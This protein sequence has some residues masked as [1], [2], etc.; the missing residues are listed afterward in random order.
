MAGEQRVGRKILITGAPG[1]GKTILVRRVAEKVHDLEPVGF[2]IEEI[3]EHGER[4][5]FSIESFEGKR[6]VLAHTKIAGRY[7]IGKY[8]VDIEGFER[9]LDGIGWG[10]DLRPVIIDEIGRM[11]CLSPKFRALID[12]LMASRRTLLA[13]IALKGDAYIEGLKRREDVMLHVIGRENREAMITQVEEE[14][15]GV[16][17]RG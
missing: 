5:G 3:R 10:D 14:M 17:R 11:E 7:R 16:E 9:F 6:A 1:V 15:R 12:K 2:W 4:I 8:R 13:T